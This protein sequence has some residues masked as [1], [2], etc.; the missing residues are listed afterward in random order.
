[1]TLPQLSIRRPVLAIVVNLIIVLIGMIC[2]QRLPVRQLP[3][4]FA[5]LAAELGQVHRGTG[6]G[7]EAHK[8]LCAGLRVGE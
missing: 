3:R 1:M 6:R 4:D 7:R 2:Y 8:C 5:E